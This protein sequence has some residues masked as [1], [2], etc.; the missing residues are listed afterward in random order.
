LTG[1][2]DRLDGVVFDLGGWTRA[3]KP[4]FYDPSVGRVAQLPFVA[5]GAYDAP[6]DI[7]AREIRYRSHDGVEVPMSIV[8]RKD[9]KLDGSHPTILYGYGAYGLTEDPFL[10]PRWYAWVQRG[11]VLAFAHVRG[12]GAF[13]EEW[14]LA[15]RKA[16]KPNT[17]KDAIAAAEWLVAKGYE[18]VE[19]RHLRR[20]R[21]YLRRPRDHRAGRTCSPQRC[22]RS[23]SSTRRASSCVERRGEFPSSAR[24]GTSRSSRP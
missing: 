17:W 16:T 21:R 9:A 18:Q 12:G 4:W 14:H 7:M 10:N 19:D 5:P 11:G 6:D 20:R 24:S 3:T 15:G 1:A 13:G 8:M 22:P 23:G 2:S